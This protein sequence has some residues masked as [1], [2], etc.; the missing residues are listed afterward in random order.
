MSDSAELGTN[1]AARPW[2]D[3]AAATSSTGPSTEFAREEAYLEMLYVRLEAVR[4]LQKQRLAEVRLAP[5]GGTP[6]SRTERDAL[7]RQLERRL[8]SLA[9]G[10]LPLCFGRLDLA[11][12]SVLYV[13]R[14]GIAG[15]GDDP[16][17]M[18][19]RAPKAALFYRATPGSPE[20][21]SRRRH[22]ITRGRRLVGIED[23]VF[24]V[25]ALRGEEIHQL[26]GDAALLAELSRARTGHMRDIVATIQRE[27]DAVIRFELAGTLVV[28]GGPGTGKTAVGLHRAAYLLYTHRSR[29]E[30]SGVL[31]VGPNPVFLRYIEQVLPALGET[32]TLTA[33]VRSLFPGVR[34]ARHDDEAVAELKSRPVMVDLIANAIRDRQRPPKDD[35]EIV[36]ERQRVV[37][38]RAVLARARERGRRAGRP[39]NEA[40]RIVEASIID[41]ALA[42]IRR[43]RSGSGSPE[44][45]AEELSSL[46]RSL[47]RARGFRELMERLWPILSPQQLLN[48]LFGSSALVRSAA[49]GLPGVD[50]RLLVRERFPEPDNGPWTIE[51]VVLLDE[52]AEQ[53]GSWTAAAARRAER[54][55]A[56][57]RRRQV[58]YA[59][60]VLRSL[61]LGIDIDPEQFAERFA[62]DDRASVAEQA[63]RDRTWRFGHVI[64]DEAQELSPM[65][66]RAVFRR[67]PSRSMTVLGDLAQ[68][69]APWAPMQWSSVLEPFARGHWRLI[70]L[71]TNYRTPIE[72][73]EVANAVLAVAAPGFRPT[74]AIRSSGQP[75]TRLAAT[76]PTLPA[77][78]V[79][80]AASLL[81]QLGE[82]RVAVLAPPRLL[83][84]IRVALD[85]GVGPLFDAADPL[86]A[87]VALLGVADAKG[88][89]FDAVVLV[90]PG[91]IAGHGPRGENDLYVALTRPTRRL[92]LLHAGTLTP[93]LEANVALEHDVD[94]GPR[95]PDTVAR[96][97][98]DD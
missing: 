52:A 6:Q 97:E 71:S 98:R 49:R 65:A 82:G 80:A 59:R 47:R 36:F 61:H 91:E 70:E 31:I 51:D 7:A 84:A 77:L 20:G 29:L 74:I 28:Q 8:D 60:T 22:F 55:E 16:L 39:H 41:S 21:V 85:E 66:W 30:R 83:D 53:L 10:D 46:R 62:G 89:E 9:I 69:G 1:G 56:A 94:A 57:R 4:N 88:L 15:D 86:G 64:V 72:I 76:A 87:R 81:E 38:S 58:G 3:G 14:V 37:L 63:V 48:D 93:E 43:E 12:G 25:E 67:V 17:L 13:G 19:W 92:L 26:R 75:P 27:Q 96:P 73:M 23:E 68:S 32:G 34:P 45:G 42:Q 11:D 50:S 24:D 54:V 5:P 79:K 95:S 90:E 33:T 18:D 40:R 35:T 78:A 2:K 44:P